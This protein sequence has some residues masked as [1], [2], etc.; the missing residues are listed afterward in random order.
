MACITTAQ[1]CNNHCNSLAQARD[2]T[3]QQQEHFDTYTAFLQQQRRIV[4]DLLDRCSDT[5]EVVRPYTTTYRHRHN[6]LTISACTSQLWKIVTFRNDEA[7]QATNRAMQASLAALQI[8]AAQSSQENAILARVA[9]QGQRDSKI[10][11][12][13]TIIATTYLPASLMAVS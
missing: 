3:A 1:Q 10:L 5:T 8:I 6:V 9:Q 2:T 12:I 11:K 13:L 7:V 4:T